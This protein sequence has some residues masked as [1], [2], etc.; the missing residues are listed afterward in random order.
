MDTFDI[1]PEKYVTL[2]DLAKR[3]GCSK[4]A[5]WKR[6]NA[7]KLGRRIGKHVAI[8]EAEAS[9]VTIRSY[10]CRR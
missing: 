2:V 1:R 10:R 5:L 8:T 9:T 6:V 3:L 7:G 4:S